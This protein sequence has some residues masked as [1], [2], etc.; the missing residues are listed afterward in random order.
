MGKDI[1]SERIIKQAKRALECASRSEKP[2]K[3]WHITDLFPDDIIAHLKELQFSVPDLGGVSG[4]RELHNEQRHYFDRA[5]R[6]RIPVVAAIAEAYQSPELAEFIQTVFGADID[7]TFLRIE[8]AQDIDGFWLEPHTDLGVKRL[9]MLIYLSEDDPE[10]PLGTDIYSADKKW[11]KR[12]PFAPNTAMAFVP[13]EDTYHG[14]E[15]RPIK[16]VRKSLILNYV[17]TQWR[18]RE[19]LAF[20]DELISVA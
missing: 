11:V 5:N 16:G 15:K 18:D 3:H 17:T 1:H 2:Y 20:P 19:Q 14:F 7:G 4:K 6:D 9:T 10:N 12:A 13:S 8:Y